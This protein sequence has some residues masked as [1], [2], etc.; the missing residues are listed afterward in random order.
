MNESF[1]PFP[2]AMYNFNGPN[3]SFSEIVNIAP[4]E[5]KISVSFTSE[6]NWEALAFP[7]D[8]SSRRN[9]VNK[10]REILITPIRYVYAKLK[11][12][13]DRFAANP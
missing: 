1:P 8:Y 11:Y 3:I 6:S 5:G 7:K 4:E 9:H 2:T 10:E 13:N 12:W